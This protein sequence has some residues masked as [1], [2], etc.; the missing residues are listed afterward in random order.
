V[1]GASG[2]LG[3]TIH[4]PFK[5]DEEDPASI[6]RQGND[7]FERARRDLFPSKSKEVNRFPSQGNLSPSVLGRADCAMEEMD[8]EGFDDEDRES[9]QDRWRESPDFLGSTVTASFD[10]T[11]R[12]TSTI[13]MWNGHEQ[14]EELARVE[15]R[16]IFQ[17][18]G[19]VADQQLPLSLEVKALGNYIKSLQDRCHQNN[20]VEACLR[21]RIVLLEQER[22]QSQRVVESAHQRVLAAIDQRVQMA[23][24]LVLVQNELIEIRNKNRAYQEQLASYQ[25]T[26]KLAEVDLFETLDGTLNGNSHHQRSGMHEDCALWS[27]D[28]EML[29][30]QRR[31]L[32]KIALRVKKACVFQAWSNWL[33]HFYDQRRLAR[34]AL[35]VSSRRQLMAM[36]V[37]L[38]VWKDVC[39]GTHRAAAELGNSGSCAC[40]KGL[41]VEMPLQPYF[42]LHSYS[43]K[44]RADQTLREKIALRMTKVSMYNMWAVWE[45]N[46]RELRRQLQGKLRDVE[47]RAQYE[48]TMLNALDQDLQLHVKYTLTLSK[49]FALWEGATERCRQLEC[50][51]QTLH[52]TLSY[53]ASRLLLRVSK[54]A[55]QSWRELSTAFTES[56]ETDRWW[57]SDPESD[58]AKIVAW[59]L[60]ETSP[61]YPLT[62]GENDYIGG[63]VLGAIGSGMMEERLDPLQMAFSTPMAASVAGSLPL[64]CLP[65]RGGLR[66]DFHVGLP[67]SGKKRGIRKD[68]KSGTLAAGAQTLVD[69]VAELKSL[70]QSE[71][72]TLEETMTEM[73]SKD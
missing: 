51:R 19:D 64:L 67:P 45:E 73:R 72:D 35:R 32:A 70:V 56:F 30:R 5:R 28:L 21:Q 66:A 63:N 62:G 37:P 25:H 59:T 39:H 53:F 27:H 36:F 6:R 48:E 42:N 55:F 49:A 16:K 7:Y 29:R 3:P 54:R 43:I 24:N 47:T 2:G 17:L 68:A 12:E 10:R 38:S 52:R 22:R 11:I 50:H 1:K 4:H 58:C 57:K 46:V 20:N 61:L 71:V 14:E 15:I 9:I 44:P 69:F 13:F 18:Q 31:V 41:S 26:L 8:D 34:A 65:D 23:S 33:G 60:P 40:C